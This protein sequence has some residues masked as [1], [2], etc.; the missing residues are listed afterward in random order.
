MDISG[1][2]IRTA[3]IYILWSKP[4][5]AIGRCSYSTVAL[6]VTLCDNEH[7]TVSMRR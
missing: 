5:A 3:T 4:V 2:S 7:V 1:G 6:K